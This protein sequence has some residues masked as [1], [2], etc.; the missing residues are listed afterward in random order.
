MYYRK[1]DKPVD[2]IVVKENYLTKSSNYSSKNCKFPLWLLIIIIVLII[3][4]GIFLVLR[5]MDKK[6]STQ[7]F[8]YKFY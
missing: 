3:G 7:N 2:S 4:I 6:K 5:F 8:G 1:N